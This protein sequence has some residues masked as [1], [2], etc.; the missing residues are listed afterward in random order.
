MRAGPPQSE[1]AD[2]RAGRLVGRTI[3]GKF[4]I[5]AV[6]SSGAMGVL[7]R[8]RQIALDKVVAI[9]VLHED[10][11]SK[12]EFAARFH[13]EAKAA[14]RLDHPNS[15]RILDFGEEPDG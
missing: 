10:L 9:K 15:I 8:A 13:I 11:G 3:G 4:A 1:R 7:Y 5:E 12:R 14:S 2:G 6:V